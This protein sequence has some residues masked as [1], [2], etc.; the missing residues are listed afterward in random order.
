MMV[1]VA[2]CDKRNL[3]VSMC[4]QSRCRTLQLGWE[5]WDTT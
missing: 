5:C 2:L 4:S 3:T 1:T